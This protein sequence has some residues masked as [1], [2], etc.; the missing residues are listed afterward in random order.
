LRFIEVSD[1]VGPESDVMPQLRT[2]VVN[3]DPTT[4][5]LR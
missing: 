3:V 5:S 4:A 1:L 2:E